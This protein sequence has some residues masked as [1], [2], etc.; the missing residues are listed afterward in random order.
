MIYNSK[1]KI[2]A[3]ELE[4]YL[5]TFPFLFP[6]TFIPSEFA[7]RKEFPRASESFV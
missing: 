3:A 1:K 7:V 4:D 6:P 5:R 2:F